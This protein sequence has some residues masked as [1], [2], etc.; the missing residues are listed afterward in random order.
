MSNFKAGDRV[1]VFSS[2]SE[3]AMAE[4]GY[5]ADKSRLATI[6]REHLSEPGTFEV[7]YDDDGSSEF[8]TDTL[9]LRPL[10]ADPVADVAPTPKK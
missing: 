10:P 9:R 5:I 2:S 3:A 4:H 8:V 6:E 7:T 1:K